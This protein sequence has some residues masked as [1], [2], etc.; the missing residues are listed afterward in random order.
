MLVLRGIAYICNMKM[1]GKFIM[2]ITLL[3]LTVSMLRAQGRADDAPPSTKSVYLTPMCVYQ[4]DTIPCVQLSTVYIFKPMVFKNKRDMRRYYRLIRDVK[5]VLLSA[6]ANAE[7]NFGMDRSDL[8]VAETFAD[9]GP[10]L[11]RMQ[12]VSKG[13]GHAILKRTSHITVIL[14]AKEI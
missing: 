13:R 5:K 14:D 2:T 11:K 9:G 3:C 6:A 1:R 10:H 12:P 8:Y 4:G 7:H